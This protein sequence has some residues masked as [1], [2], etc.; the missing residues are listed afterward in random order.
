VP[1]LEEAELVAAL[2]LGIADATAAIVA[3]RVGRELRVVWAREFT[4]TALLDVGRTLRDL[5]VRHLL[6]PHDAE[7]RELTT[8][9]TRRE[10]L[11]RLG[12]STQVVPRLSVEEGI[13]AAA[14]LLPHCAFDERHAAPLLNAL[15]M[16]RREVRDDGGHSAPV[17]DGASHFADAFRYLALGI[18]AGADIYRD[19]KTGQVW[20]EK[21][22]IT[23]HMTRGSYTKRF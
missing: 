11:E 23:V 6:L 4:G 20:R 1:L 12:F 15:E 9:Q 19:P 7:V 18:G 14:A 21:R 3:Q 8:A 22:S 2:D 16:Y 17:H 5:G 10:A 13:A